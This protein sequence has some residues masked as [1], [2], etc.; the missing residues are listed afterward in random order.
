ME[1]DLMRTYVTTT[2]SQSARKATDLKC[3]LCK[4]S[5]PDS[6]YDVDIRCR[7]NEGS[8]AG[9]H[10]IHHTIDLCHR[11]F[12]DQLLPVI[13]REL[14]ISAQVETIDYKLT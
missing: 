9:G 12:K 14:G 4:R 6:L 13:K 5:L 2:Y 10:Y 11:C 7:E 8:I 3:D 1:G